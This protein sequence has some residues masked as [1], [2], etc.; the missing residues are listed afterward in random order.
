MYISSNRDQII[1]TIDTAPLLVENSEA[2]ELQDISLHLQPYVVKS[3][4]INLHASYR[5]C[6]SSIAGLALALSIRSKQLDN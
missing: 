5:P 4:E 2:R 6:S 3:A 1:S